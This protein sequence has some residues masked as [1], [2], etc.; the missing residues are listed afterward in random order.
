MIWGSSYSCQEGF[1][2]QMLLGSWQIH[3][4]PWHTR[5]PVLCCLI[6][7][8]HCPLQIPVMCLPMFPRSYSQWRNCPGSV[9][10][11]GLMKTSAWLKKTHKGFN[12]WNEFILIFKFCDQ[13]VNLLIHSCPKTIFRTGIFTYVSYVPRPSNPPS[14]NNYWTRSRHDLIIL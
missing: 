5:M 7:L 11:A 4:E 2:F 6:W 3:H 9:I 1:H 13:S 14:E 8:R 10:A 12:V